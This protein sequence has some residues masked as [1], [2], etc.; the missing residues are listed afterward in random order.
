M[1][2]PPT[3]LKNVPIPPKAHRRTLA[4]LVEWQKF[5]NTME[6]GDCF[7]THIPSLYF[8]FLAYDLNVKI[9]SRFDFVRQITKI[10]RVG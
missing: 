5:F 2:I 10:W 1:M 4:E 6:V 7:E 9:V 8:Y 3:I